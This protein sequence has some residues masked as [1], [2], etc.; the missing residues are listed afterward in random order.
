MRVSAP[1][2]LAQGRAHLSG[3]QA[4]G[5]LEPRAWGPGPG[6][7]LAG[8]QTEGD[9]SRTDGAWGLRI[10]TLP[11]GG[12]LAGPSEGVQAPGNP[13]P[14]R[15]RAALPASSP[16]PRWRPQGTE[17]SRPRDPYVRTPTHTCTC[18]T[19]THAQAHAHMPARARTGFQAGPGFQVQ[20][21][22]LMAARSPRPSLPGAL[23]E[24]A[25]CSSCPAVTRAPEA[26]P[27]TLH[28]RSHLHTLPS[29]L[30]WHQPYERQ[31][32]ELRAS[33]CPPSLSPV[34]EI[35]RASCRERVSS[36]V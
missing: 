21:G 15:G 5:G 33:S 20:P 10:H 27:A 19:C 36:P 6:L 25:R 22:E 14:V 35:G 12:S 31:T 18:G 26:L 1:A 16:S 9:A 8:T 4:G 23:S 13:I 32:A 34:R 30:V 2:E 24:V 17:G 3:A 7:G 11:V 29:R 28:T